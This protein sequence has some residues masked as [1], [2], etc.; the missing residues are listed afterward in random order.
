MKN[1]YDLQLAEGVKDTWKEYLPL[2]IYED[3]PEYVS[4]YMKAW[5][6]AYAHIKEIPGMPQSPYMD[7]AFCNTQI[8]I[9][10]TC[11]MSL[12]CKYAP[13]IFPGVESLRNF[14]EVLYQNRKLPMIIPAEKELEWF[15]GTA[16][17]PYPMH[18]HIADNP[19]LFAWSEYEN[20]KMKG[21][22][23]YLK[24]LLYKERFLQQHYEW[25][26]NLRQQVLLPGVFVPTCLIAESLGYKWEGGRSGMDNTP[27][28]R[29]GDHAEEQR[30]N[31]PNMLWLDAI[32]QQALVA[33]KISELFAIVG[34]EEEM[35]SWEN[36]FLEKQ[37]VVNQYYWDEKDA[38]YY[39]IDCDSHD[40][41]RVKTIASYW[42][43]TSEVAPK[44]RAAVLV[45]ELENPKTFGGTV[46]FPSLAR[47]DGD[48]NS[49]GEYWRGAIWLP[50]AYAALTGMKNYAFY[51]Q[52]HNLSSSLLEH[53]YRT[54]QEFE[55][56]TIWEC[57]SPTQHKP[58]CIE[59]GTD[60]LVRPDFCGWS[61]LGPI[62]IF[63]EFVL[64]FHTIDAF[65][66][67]VDWA[68]P[69]TDNK[70]GI[71]NLSFGDVK[72]DIE[73]VGNRISVKSNGPYTLVINGVVHNI[74][75][76]ENSIVL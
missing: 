52:A 28:G 66:K 55:P 71:K 68:K 53:M 19:P 39:D 73:A 36:R 24:Q 51:Q 29:S 27:R 49:D 12:F 31:N 7:E 5:E 2:P 63:I 41:Y 25:F 58:A 56:H 50:T 64:G 23:A 1:E 16:G 35:K 34:N 15:D 72:T 42:T 69:Q 11:F 38:F 44:E 14:Y 40:F 22:I 59:D 17:E 26:E 21:D 75:S 32:C 8:W 48:F 60:E 13:K 54:Y 20:A 30:P 47:N 33:K 6:L 43:L 18:V 37:N 45:K 3:H 57:Y 46:P 65:H 74:E 9:W 67:R 76:G 70:I 10:D 62:S 4:F 61:A